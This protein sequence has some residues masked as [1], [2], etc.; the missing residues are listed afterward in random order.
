MN[1]LSEEHN[2]ELM[3]KTDYLYI[4]FYKILTDMT[5]TT[6]NGLPIVLDYRESSVVLPKY[7]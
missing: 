6:I 4:A 3:E 7:F 1:Y 2:E 5:Q